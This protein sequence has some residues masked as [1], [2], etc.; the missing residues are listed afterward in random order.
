MGKISVMGK[1]GDTKVIWDASKPDEV[2]SARRTFDDLKKKKYIAFKVKK[3]GSQGEVISE[4][5]PDAE[6]IILAPPM[7]GG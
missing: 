5:D 6:K 3:D 7:S 2:E 1:E 4:F